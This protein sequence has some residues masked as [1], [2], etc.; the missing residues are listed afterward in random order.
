MTIF[1][2]AFIRRS[3]GA[4]PWAIAVLL[5]VVLLFATVALHRMF[6]DIE[7][8]E[9][10]RYFDSIVAHLESDLLQS[11]ALHETMQRRMATRLAY[12]GPFDE[13]AWRADALRLI[14]DYPYYRYLTVLEGDFR[15]R[16]IAGPDTMQIGPG[17]RL[18]IS[19]ELVRS[20][21]AGPPEMTTRVVEVVRLADGGVGLEFVTPI[22]VNGEIAN[23]LVA[24][25][26]LR[27]ALKS[28]LTGL[29]MRDLVLTGK[30]AG[31]E[32]TL[33]E[34]APAVSERYRGPL[35]F[36]LADSSRVKLS[37]AMRTATVQGM[38]S[39]LP[40]AVL[41]AGISLSLV[42]VIAALLA[43]AAARQAR[44]LA[45]ANRALESEVRDRRLAE[46]ELGFLLIHDSLTGLP[47]RQGITRA[48]EAALARR[49]EHHLLGALFIDLDQFKDINETLGHHL[50]D[51]LLS[52]IPERLQAELG[53]D[54]AIGRLGGDEFLVVSE[55]RDHTRIVKLADRLL[56]AFDQP[57]RINEHQLFVTASIGI[58]CAS[59]SATSPAD[60]IRNADAAVFRAKQLG[61]NQHA[62]FTPEM[63]ARVEYRLNLSRDLRQALDREEFRVHYQPI[64]DL[65]TLEM[66][67]VE[68]LL[69][70][71]H[72]DGYNVPP[73]DFIRVAEETGFVHRLSKFALSLAV[74]DL[75]RW[76]REFGDRA[77]WLAVNISGAQFREHDFVRD[78]SMLLHHHRVLPE[79]VHLEIT[80]EVLIENLARNREILEQ[81]VEIGMPIAVDDFG[82]GY[83]SLAYVKNFPVSTIK[84]DQG[85]IRNLERDS[86]DQAITRTICNLSR[87]LKLATV[88]EGIEQPGQ[89]R[90][91]GEFGCQFGQGFLFHQPVP[92]AEIAA[93][94]ARGAP[95]PARLRDRGPDARPDAAGRDG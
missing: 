37:A 14:E 7:Q 29:Y 26:D 44:V 85:F 90:L 12:D 81:L 64:V 68:A 94:L 52:L 80:E 32:I 18:S 28:M 69:R 45:G 58:A 38:R 17:D 65:Q 77:P 40:Q 88:A 67:G 1:D 53:E 60:L 49:S 25:L 61:R 92:A 71:P 93:V 57:F 35:E 20:L 56:A 46:R 62:E 30:F 79:R 70:W 72:P 23:W 82:I 15:V 87:D 24:M 39:G 9:I 8:T 89:L 41:I 76:Q 11:S 47:N 55:Q 2:A 13:A 54:D 95:W 3:T 16:W 75:A 10:Q 63:F 86:E 73:R 36:L 31:R 6:V 34:D 83:S 78:L 91:L 51:Q 42:I 74:G 84:I 33:P 21:N 22:V 48:L 66:A 59:D 50:G 5:L 43:M 27:Q 4:T 19:P